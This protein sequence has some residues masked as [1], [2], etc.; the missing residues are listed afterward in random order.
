LP[1]RNNSCFEIILQNKFY[2]IYSFSPQ[3]Q[4]A[5][6]NINVFL[7]GAMEQTVSTFNVTIE[8]CLEQ[9]NIQDLFHSLKNPDPPLLTG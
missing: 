5:T 8:K 6:E 1:T 4:I 7:S 2:L 3:R 9:F